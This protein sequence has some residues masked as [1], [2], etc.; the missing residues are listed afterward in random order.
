ML[1]L[2]VLVGLFILRGNVIWKFCFWCF[3]LIL[4]IF[5]VVFRVLIVD[6]FFFLKV[7]WFG[8]K[9][10]LL[11]FIDLDFDILFWLYGCYLVWKMFFLCVKL[12]YFI[13][14][15][16]FLGW[17]FLLF[18]NV[19]FGFFLVFFVRINFCLWLLI[20]VCKGLGFVFILWLFVVSFE[21]ILRFFFRFLIKF[22]IRVRLL[23]LMIFF[24]E[25]K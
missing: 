22:L 1:L 6:E 21:K 2:F 24:E 9:W 13:I 12:L 5:L 3:V 17:L 14:E 7:F 20:L 23:F 15:V 8:G 19:L 25:G 16:R 18:V 4:W 10:L 11:F